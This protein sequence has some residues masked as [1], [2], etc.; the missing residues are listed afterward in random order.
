[1]ENKNNW[2][3]FNPRDCFFNVVF[4]FPLLDGGFRVM[5]VPLGVN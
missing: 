5:V 1:M 2:C 4:M 3:E